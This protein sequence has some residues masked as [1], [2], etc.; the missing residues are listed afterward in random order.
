MKRSCLVSIIALL[1]T[2]L[3]G[4]NS[5]AQTI[6]NP[7]FE[8]N[9]FTVFPGYCSSNGVITGWTA[10]DAAA[11][12]LNSAGD[13][14]FANN[15]VTPNGT[16]VAFIQAA[17]GATNW[18][19]TTLSNLTAGTLYRVGCRV[20]SRTNYSLPAMW[21]ALNGA[22]AYTNAVPPVGVAGS[23]NA[24]AYAYGVFTAASNTSPLLMACTAVTTN[25]YGTMDGALLVDDF[26]VAALETNY[27]TV[28]PWVSDAT[29]GVDMANT[30]WAYAFG[31]SS[32]L[33]VNGVP[34]LAV[35]GGNP[36]VAG[37]FRVAGDGY[38]YA[39]EE[40]DYLSGAGSAALAA[41]F[42]YGGDPA[43]VTVS[44]LVVV[45]GVSADVLRGG[46]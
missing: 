29:A 38:A 21:L 28:A 30:L 25:S 44:N 3:A 12:G 24:Y 36:A 26:Q 27:F 13:N 41:A 46:V 2:T 31:T 4:T 6:Y 23:T 42:I 33:T 19:A 39:G 22:V 7:S 16:N 17:G 8:L 18:L 34:F 15:G 9:W 43:I 20:N 35:T 45:G 32:N 40:P 37:L 5:P 11:V 10:S 14:P 1:L